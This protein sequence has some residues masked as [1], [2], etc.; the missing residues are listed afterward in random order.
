MVHKQNYQRYYEKARR[1]KISGVVFNKGPKGSAV[2]ITPSALHRTKRSLTVWLPLGC[3]KRW[4]VRRSERTTPSAKCRLFWGN[5]II[6]C[7]VEPI[8]VP[9]LRIWE[10]AKWKHSSFEKLVEIRDQL[11][12]FQ[13]GL[14]ITPRIRGQKVA[15]VV[16]IF[17]TIA[18]KCFSS[19][20]WIVLGSKNYE[21]YNVTSV[22]WASTKE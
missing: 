12:K 3:T 18:P 22:Q 7:V 16:P 13:S 10:N 1:V 20:G 8:R 14:K 4:F 5:G 21:G 15:K 11:G 2:E 19:R 6:T 9:D 17:W